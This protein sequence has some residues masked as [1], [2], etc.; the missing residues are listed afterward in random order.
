M[1]SFP[2]PEA[3]TQCIAA[4]QADVEYRS[5]MLFAARICRESRLKAVCVPQCG[6]CTMA[7][8]RVPGV[9]HVGME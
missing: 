6:H 4:G 5:R 9:T 3:N 1:L 7:E 8:G 2:L